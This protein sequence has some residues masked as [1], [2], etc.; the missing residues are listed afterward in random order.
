M[1]RKNR[2]K[3]R[4]DGRYFALVSTGKYLQDGSA[5]RIPLYSSISSKDLEEKVD[6]LKATIKTSVYVESTDI[7]LGDYILNWYDT[8]KAHRSINTKAMYTNIINVHI[9]PNL[10][11]LSLANVT[12]SNIQM[13]INLTYQKQRTC[14]QIRLVLKQVFASALKEKIILESP[15][16]DIDMPSDKRKKKRALTQI[17]KNAIN[18]AD[19][20]ISERTFILILYGCGLRREEILA[21]HQNDIDL[22]QRCVYVRHVIVFDKNTPILEESTKTSSGYRSIPIPIFMFDSIKFY[23]R[24]L[25]GPLLFTSASGGYITKSAYRRL[26]DRIL[27]KLNA[28]AATPFNSTPIQGLTAHI[29]RHNYC[30]MLYYSGLSELKSVELMGHADGKMIREVYAHLNEEKENTVEKLDNC[31]NLEIAL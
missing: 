21:L 2:Y 10:G 6:A 22:I 3:P 25:N 1:P 15:W 19:L 16:Y 24:T 27:V 11:H 13:L 20:T 31:I 18:K 12:R 14:E 26:W 28:A 9:I 4:K 8:Y 5:E 17:E 7:L 30:S 29:F 23:L